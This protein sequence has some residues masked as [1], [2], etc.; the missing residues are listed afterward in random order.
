MNDLHHPCQPW[1][2]RLSLAAA[3]CLSPD[4]DRAVRQ[5]AETCAACGERLRELTRLCGAL[6]ATRSPIDNT[7][8]ASVE[9][10]LAAVASGVSERRPGGMGSEMIHPT[11]LTRSLDTW[12]WIMRHP[13]SAATATTVLFVAIF[14]IAFWFHVG[15]VTPA[16]ADFLQPILEAKALKYQVTAKWTR[17]PPEWEILPAEQQKKFLAAGVTTEV[18]MLG[19]DRVREES[20]GPDN[21]KVVHIWDGRQGKSL[22]LLPDQKRA[23]LSTE[24]STSEHK[25][26]HGAQQDTAAVFRTLLLHACNRPGVKAESLGEK[27]IDG[28]RVVGVRITLPVAVMNV[29][30]DPKTGL[31]YRIESTTRMMPDVQ[32]TWSDFEFNVP[33]E[34]SLFSVEPPA[35]YRVGSFFIE[36]PTYDG[37]ATDEKDLVETFREYSRLSGGPF[38]PSLDM[39][40]LTGIVMNKFSTDRMQKP[41]AREEV[42]QIQTKLLRGMWF[43]TMLPEQSDAHYAGEGVSL[44]A[45][46]KPIFWYRPKDA[47][48]YRVIYADLSGREADTPPSVPNA[49]PVPV[50]SKGHTVQNMNVDTCMR[51]EGDLITLFREY[52][53]RMG[54]ALPPSLDMQRIMWTLGARMG[55]EDA[56]PADQHLSDV[57]LR[58]LAEA[59]S[60]DDIEKIVQAD[61]SMQKAKAEPLRK[62]KSAKPDSAKTT[63]GVIKAAEPIMRGLAFISALPPDADAHYAGKGVSLGTVDRPIFWYRPK[64]AKKYRVIYAD[65]SVREAD[66]PPG[67]P[68]AQPVPMRARSKG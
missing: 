28:R 1:A 36:T 14:A 44:G 18:M 32:F 38:P 43:S 23:T 34:E 50:R 67:V 17:I 10:I 60:H 45:A 46:D 25:T 68:N 27:E 9:R 49:Q 30:G 12:R 64:G 54:N 41:G 66:T 52:G 40:G 24:A 48:K 19:A 56:L 6:S 58:K 47:K 62:M 42:K 59:Q 37:S 16:Y 39:M 2:Q 35:G 33:M 26:P 63:T 15:G 21:S 13:I 51:M 22:S 31:P 53:K 29:W 65:L 4:E 20:V 3:G 5:H 57:S 55:L 61:P 8:A 11:L 7:E